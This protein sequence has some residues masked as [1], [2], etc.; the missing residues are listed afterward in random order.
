MFR[1]TAHRN[2]I[3]E[4]PGIKHQLLQKTTKKNGHSCGEF[5]KEA[6]RIIFM[7]LT[8]IYDR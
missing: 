5:C 8:V 6:E 4:V 1:K 3:D 7:S 2:T